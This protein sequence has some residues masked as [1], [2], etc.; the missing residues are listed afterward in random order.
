MPQEAGTV[1][2]LVKRGAGILLNKTTDIVPTIQSLVG[3]SRRYS[4]LKAATAG[5]ATPGS[6]DM[7]VREIAALLPRNS[8][9]PDKSPVTAAA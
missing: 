8:E 4:E 3:N 9:L 6:R 5:I 7:I 2:L 1:K